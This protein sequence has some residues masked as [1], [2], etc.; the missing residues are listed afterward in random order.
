MQQTLDPLHYRV[1]R[2]HI[3]RDTVRGMREAGLEIEELERLQHADVIGVARNP[4][5]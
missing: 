1:F 3:G 4:S 2:C 5:R